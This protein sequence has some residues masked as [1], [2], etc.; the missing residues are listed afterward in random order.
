MVRVQSGPGCSRLG[1][2]GPLAPHATLG[3]WYPGCAEKGSRL[4][5]PALTLTLQPIPPTPMD[6]LALSQLP[7]QSGGGGVKGPDRQPQVDHNTSIFHSLASRLFAHP[8]HL[9][10]PRAAGRGPDARSCAAGRVGS[11]PRSPAPVPWPQ[12]SPSLSVL[13]CRMG[14]NSLLVVGGD[15]GRCGCHPAAAQQTVAVRIVPEVRHR[16]TCPHY[17]MKLQ[18]QEIAFEKSQNEQ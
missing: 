10:G 4:Q 14:L 7:P 1:S 6:F 18:K 16:V 8:E 2:R 3:A 12:T 11:N 13:I 9:L 17:C 5:G 15:C